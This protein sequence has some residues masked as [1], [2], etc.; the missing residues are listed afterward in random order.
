MT[1][2]YVQSVHILLV[3]GLRVGRPQGGDELPETRH[4]LRGGPHEERFI[5]IGTGTKEEV[6]VVVY[7]YR[8]TNIRII[9]ARPAESHERWQY[10][11]NR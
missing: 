2:L 7:T 10:E 8:G 3:D 4:Q 11:V 5:S 1:L 9:S 6:L